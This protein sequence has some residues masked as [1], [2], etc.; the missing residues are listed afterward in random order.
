VEFIQRRNKK[1]EK[2]TENHCH[3]LF[4]RQGGDQKARETSERSVDSALPSAITNPIRKRV[5]FAAS[6]LATMW[7]SVWGLASWQRGLDH[8]QG[9]ITLAVSVVSVGVVVG[10]HQTKW[11]QKSIQGLSSLYLMFVSIAIAFAEAWSGRGITYTSGLSLGTLW[12]LM[13]PMLVPCSA[14]QTFYKAV[15]AASMTPLALVLVSLMRGNNLWSSPIDLLFMVAPGYLAAALAWSGAKAVSHLGVELNQAYRMGMYELEEPLGHG[16]MG[17]VWRAKHAFLARPAAV[18]LIRP[19]AG[20]HGAQPIDSVVVRRFER[21]AQVTALLQSPHTVQLYDF[22]VTRDGVFYYVMELLS[23]MN[24]EE[25]VHK[26]GPLPPERAVRIL[27]QVLDSLIEAHDHSLI[28]RDIKP[29]NIQL[30]SRNVGE[31]IVKV[32]DFGLVKSVEKEPGVGLSLTADNQVAG[33]PA[34]MPPEVLTGEGKVDARADLYALGCVAF[35]LLTGQT[36]FEGATAM[37]IAIAHVTQQPRLPSEVL[38]KKLPPMLEQI[39]LTCLAKK[40]EDRPETSRHLAYLLNLWLE[41][42]AGEEQ[43]SRSSIVIP[44]SGERPKNSSPL[45]FQPTMPSMEMAG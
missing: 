44:S 28:H 13:F 26:H 36:V 41:T 18:K 34:Y 12:I 20:I 4:C 9:W 37:Q 27:L 29:A 25:L 32:L 33:T 42:Y 19:Q 39:I 8:V 10:V 3:K 2:T 38:G 21:E 30:S 11:E 15:A 22:G 45:S 17:E 14:R 5:S 24:L 31:D 1:T 6:T 43:S 16:G 7:I 23:G 35:W 40:P